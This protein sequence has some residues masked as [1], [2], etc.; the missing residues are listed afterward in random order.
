RFSR[1]W[2]SDVC[3]SDLRALLW[4]GWE[5]AG[6]LRIRPLSQEPSRG[7]RI[8]DPEIGSEAVTSTSNAH[9]PHTRMVGRGGAC[10]HPKR[11]VFGRTEELCGQ[12][13]RNVLF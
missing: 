1:D 9:P 13:N 3:S 10:N 11:A 6:R 5:G 4:R 8:P 7:A 12:N 2:S